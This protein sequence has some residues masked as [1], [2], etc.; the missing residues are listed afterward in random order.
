M[1]MMASR[2]GLE[3]NMSD[4]LLTWWVLLVVV[5]SLFIMK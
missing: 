5:V 2:L 1:A 4:Y 3:K